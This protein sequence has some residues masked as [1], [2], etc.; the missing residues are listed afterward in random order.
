[1]PYNGE[2]HMKAKLHAPDPLDYLIDD[3]YHD[4]DDVNRK[5]IN[6]VI[7]YGEQRLTLYIINYVVSAKL[8]W[9]LK[10]YRID[11]IK[12]DQKKELKRGNHTDA[13]KEDQVY[14][15]PDLLDHLDSISSIPDLYSNNSKQDLHGPLKHVYNR[16]TYHRE[17]RLFFDTVSLIDSTECCGRKKK[18]GEFYTKAIIRDLDPEVKLY[19]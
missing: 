14:W 5:Q 4:N 6:N 15:M 17:Q 12:F 1:M 2:C 8:E 13:N 10:K 11:N 9:S 19:H 16:K 7:D 18:E 3:T